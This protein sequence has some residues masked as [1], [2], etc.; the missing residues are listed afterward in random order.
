MTN[1]SRQ[2]KFLDK[3]DFEPMYA[4]YQLK[5][6]KRLWDYMFT[7]YETMHK[8]G[9][10]IK[11]NNYNLVYA[12]SMLHGKMHLEQIY[13]KFNIDHPADFKGHSLS[14]SDVVVTKY[15]DGSYAASYV[16][17]FGFKFIPDFMLDSGRS[18]KSGSEM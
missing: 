5:D 2:R 8:R 3:T 18:R 17:S 15:K 13:T 12:E 10:K 16:D 9:R 7:N 6:D 14:V 4:I 11:R 1:E